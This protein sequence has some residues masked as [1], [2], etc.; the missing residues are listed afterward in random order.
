MRQVV[1]GITIIDVRKKGEYMYQNLVDIMGFETIPAICTGDLKDDNVN[2]ARLY[3]ELLDKYRNNGLHPV[4][5]HKNMD[6][7]DYR[8]RVGN[9]NVFD[10]K[11][12]YQTNV[13]DILRETNYSCFDVWYGRLIYDYVLDCYKSKEEVQEYFDKLNPPASEGYNSIFATANEK[14]NYGVFDCDEVTWKGA[15]LFFDF[16][17]YEF[18]LLP[19]QNN[20]EAL[21]WFPFGRFNACPAPQYHVAFAKE[22]SQ[23][24]G[25]RIMYIG[26]NRLTYDWENPRGDKAAVEEAVKLLMVADGD[27]YPRFTETALDIIGTHTWQFWWD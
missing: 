1:I 9:S 13:E 20:W 26:I 10:T 4:L 3:R 27:V 14:D 15:E 24:Y 22:L 23:R 6:S 21:A 19:A 2:N 11:E 25:A 7:E 16:N 12:A 18:V 8:I 5:I 17:K